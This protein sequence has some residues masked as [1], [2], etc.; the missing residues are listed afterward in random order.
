MKQNDETREE[1]IENWL[2][3]NW[4]EGTTRTRK[5]EPDQTK[6]G[7]HE[8]ATRLAIDVVIPE[9]EIPE[10]AARVE[11]PGPQVATAVLDDVD[12]DDLPDWTDYAADAVEEKREAF[13]D[14]QDEDRGRDAWN[15]LVNEV[16]LDVLR[17]APGRPDVDSVRR[18]VD[19]M[20]KQVLNGNDPET[21][22][23]ERAKREAIE[24]GRDA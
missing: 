13:L 21:P 5:S 1:R 14:V 11:V 12:E 20:G 15:A 18:V 3:L 2:I 17:D 6:L 8:I 24:R 4:K 16:V 22:A 19:H 9:V 7:T 23:E 10:L